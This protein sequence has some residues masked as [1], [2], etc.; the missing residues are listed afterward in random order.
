MT[1]LNYFIFWIL[2]IYHCDILD[3]TYYR[4]PDSAI[5]RHKICFSRHIICVINFLESILEFE[6]AWQTLIQPNVTHVPFHE[7]NCPQMPDLIN[8]GLTNVDAAM[9]TPVQLWE[10][11]IMNGV[12]RLSFLHL[13]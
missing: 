4:I 13:Y 3:L 1:L 9:I 6:N 12:I 7:T 10:S 8:R 2:L 11:K 5:R